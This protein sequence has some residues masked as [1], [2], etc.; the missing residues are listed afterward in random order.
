MT[1]R[2]LSQRGAW[3]RNK[4]AAAERHVAAYLRGRGF[5]GV[6]RAVRTGYRTGDRTSADPGDLTGI[7]GVIIS[8]KD[9]QE[10]HVDAWLRELDGMDPSDTLAIRLLVIKRNRK[11]DPG[12]WRCVMRYPSFTALQ[13]VPDRGSARRFPVEVAFGDAVTL[14]VEAGYAGA[15]SSNVAT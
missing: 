5:D 10:H 12:L 7:P 2:T 9:T 8:V 3:S 15:L 1:E 6:E 4:G 13:L 14:L 11:R